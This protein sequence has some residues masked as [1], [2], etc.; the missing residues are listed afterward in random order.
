M[1]KAR[2]LAHWPLRRLGAAAADAH[3]RLLAQPVRQLRWSACDGNPRR[4]FW[5]VQVVIDDT[6]FRL[7]V[8][9]RAFDHWAA[10]VVGDA[11]PA[12]VSAGIASTGVPLWQGLSNV[13]HAQVRFVDARPM[14]ALTV[15]DDAIAWQLTEQGWH[16]VLYTYEDAAWRRLCADTPLRPSAHTGDGLMELPLEISLNVGWT[17]LSLA[18]FTRLRPHCVVLL[19]A[20]GAVH[21]Q[22]ELIRLGV[23]VLGGATRRRIARAVWA[24]DALYR[25]ADFAVENIAKADAPDQGAEMD[26]TDTQEEANHEGEPTQR[27]S[28]DGAATPARGATQPQSAPDLSDVE[29]EVRFEIGRMRWPL[30]QLVQW[31]VGQ[32]VPLEVSLRDTPVTAWVHDRR[33][34][35][36]RLIIIGERLG[37]RLDEVFTP[38]S[39]PAAGGS[40]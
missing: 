8:H 11:P 37:V 38:S 2:P 20:A 34:A 5:W 9:A 24:G 15:P 22:R 3:G 4:S 28:N 27:V 10:S 32:P 31:R 26:R 1:H 39:K 35:S 6:P 13:L 30:R 36:G 33:I 16:G 40:A 21:R 7:H 14:R 29:V 18:D 25:V 17:R 19:D 23:T 12:L